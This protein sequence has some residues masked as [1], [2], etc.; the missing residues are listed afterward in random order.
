MK[1]AVIF[2]AKSKG[3]G[4]YFQSLNSALLLKKLENNY[5]NFIFITPDKKTSIRLKNEELN[6]IFFS[7]ILLTKFF[8]QIVQVNFIKILLDFFK[9]KNPFMRFLKKNNFDFVIFLGPS[10]FIKLCDEINF[11]SS[12]YDINFKLDN[13]FP[14]YKSSI[15]FDSKNLIVK[16]SVEHAFK[17][18]VDTLRSKKELIEYYNCPDKKIIVQPFTPL[19]P[20]IDKKINHKELLNKLGLKNKKFFFYPAQFWAHK[21][22]KYIIDALKILQQNKNDI[23]FVFC[24]SDKGNLNYIKNEIDNNHL[25][26]KIV[27]HKFISDEEVIAL[28]KNCIGLVMP[29]YVARSTL[30]L[31]EAFFFKIPVFYSKGVLDESLENLVTTIDLNNPQDLSNKINKLIDGNLDVNTKI[32]KAFNHYTQSCGET[33]FLSNHQKIINEYAYQSKRWKNSH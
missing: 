21:N 22:H 31:Y 7:K 26:D 3:G 16:K 17:I 11:I 24:G 5:T 14:E 27:I 12:I 28:Y 25:Q 6:T 23:N 9:I 33:L 2:D 4:G 10:W 18:L 29:T 20:N 15:V 1:I 8:Y 32:E 19:I 30:P 13:H